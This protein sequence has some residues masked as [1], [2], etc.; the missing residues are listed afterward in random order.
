MFNLKNAFIAVAMAGVVGAFLYSKTPDYNVST[1]DMTED[2]HD[3]GAAGCVV[4]HGDHVM[5]GVNKIKPGFGD[6]TLDTIKEQFGLTHQGE[7]HD[8]M[9]LFVGRKD[10][11]FKGTSKEWAVIK[12]EDE[13]SLTFKVIG[14]KPLWRQKIKGWGKEFD[15]KD[16]VIYQCGFENDE[17]AA[18]VKKRGSAWDVP[19]TLFGVQWV[20]LRTMKDLDGKDVE[21]KMRYPEDKTRIIGKLY[22]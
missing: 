18:A 20:D 16:A 3:F 5:M 1:T 10:P 13:S 15:G 14:D 11:E 12:A 8:A 2:T 22:R 17:A 21:T 6:M 9:H 19:E 4:K 7:M